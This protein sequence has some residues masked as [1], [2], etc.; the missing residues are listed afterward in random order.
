M[1]AAASRERQRGFRTEAERR[2][3]LGQYYTGVQLARLLA[4]LARV[5]DASSVL[6]P[7]AGTGDMLAARPAGGQTLGAIEVDA[8]AHAACAAR[9]HELQVAQ[10]TALL[11]NA[12]SGEVLRQLPTLEWDVVITNPPYVRY[13]QTAARSST[14]GLELPS[15]ADVRRGLREAVDL[16]PALDEIDKKF[17][18]QIVD[19]YSGLA[20]L[21]VPSWILCAALVRPGGTLAM[22]VPNA[23]LSR[24]YARP[25]HYLLARWFDVECVIEDAEAVWFSDAL[26]RTTLLVARRVPRLDDLS[27]TS[28]SGYLHLKVGRLASDE[29]G[30]VGAAYPRVSDPELAF[31]DEVRRWTTQRRV[32]KRLGISGDWV[33][34]S[35]GHRI[36]Q[37]WLD[38][39]MGEETPSA[40]VPK[41][42]APL[43][44]RLA[45]LVSRRAA[46]TTIEEIGWR[47][48]QGLRTGANKFFYVDWVKIVEDG[49]LVSTTKALGG[50]HLTVPRE[51]LG[52]VLRR[53]SELPAA[54]V[55]D[56]SMLRGRVLLLD[57]Y[58]LPED[59][60]AVP[61]SPY[62]PLPDEFAA[63]VRLAAE[64]NIGEQDE[65]RFIP[66][67]SAVA[68]NVRA[69]RPSQP[70]LPARHWYQL[71]ALTDRHQ[72]DLFIARVNHGHPRTLINRGRRSIID[73]NFS[74][75]WKT[76]AAAA[77]EFGI[78]ALLNGSWCIAALE[79]GGTV[80]GGGAL[81]VEATHL[82]RLPIPAFDDA[83][84]RE[85]STIGRAL[86]E[87]AGEQ[88]EPLIVRVDAI[89]GHRLS[90][91]GRTKFQPKVKAIAVERLAERLR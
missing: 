30:V 10:A 27:R 76:S 45:P 40:A 82:R 89:T 44:P 57:G 43:P 56:P 65:P 87:T 34:A 22:V 33:A 53:Q 58:A 12:F 1:E 8:L 62:R 26:V 83:E 51:A 28:S 6:D 50:R 77:D 3:R 37:R 60:A 61:Q 19:G 91:A 46:F 35:H 23:W 75:L 18:Q 49:D 69:F 59:I 9:M 85:L 47:V 88:T 67:L 73:A 13:Q 74:T 16:A 17:F 71:P 24:D 84:W 20:D 68:P 31:V 78:L 5:D 90:P 63:Y 48:G 29:R 21:A 25:I 7:M 11:G 32:G 81:K 55:I 64:T 38:V 42:P 72:P 52:A 4:A 79:L 86:A 36:A 39:A 41:H 80:L 66:R 15:A 2:K 70:D 14:D 54:Y